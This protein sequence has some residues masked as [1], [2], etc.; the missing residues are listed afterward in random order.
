MRLL[1]IITALLIAHLEGM[2]QADSVTTRV[3]LVGDAGALIEGK[4]S[5]LQAIRKNVKLDKKTV[6]VY[7]GDNLYDAGLPHE[8]YTRYSQIKAALDSQLN[9]VKG[10]SAKGY[11]IPGNHDWEN[12]GVRV[13]KRSCASRIMSIS[14]AAAKLSFFQ[15]RVAQAQW[16]LNCRATLYS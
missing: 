10:T 3:I 15:N 13:M 16:R 8:T 14:M 9:L 2:A 1:I 6:I 11:M 4:P 7:L 12:G 5:V